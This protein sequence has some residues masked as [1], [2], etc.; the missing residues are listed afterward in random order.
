MLRRFFISW[1]SVYSQRM[2][3]GHSSTVEA[4]VRGESRRAMTAIGVFLFFGT[5]MAFLAG[6]TLIWQGTFLD[7]MWAATAGAYKQLAPFGRTVGILFL[8]L[9]GALAAAG[10]GKHQKK[11]THCS[12]KRC[13][14][15]EEHTSELQSHS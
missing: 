1:I 10:A 9:G 7:Q 4:N 8:V 6:T 14:R 13:E 2:R 3:S 11:N 5:I 12:S 15:S